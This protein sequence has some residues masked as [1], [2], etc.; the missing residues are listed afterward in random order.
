MST[1]PETQSPEPTPG[2]AETAKNTDEVQQPT[3]AAET[4]AD[5]QPESTA[6]DEGGHSE[7][8][9]PRDESRTEDAGDQSEAA[10]EADQADKGGAADQGD[11]ADQG[12]AA[13]KA[14]QADEKGSRRDEA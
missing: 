2:P 4:E 9:E 5:P 8:A 13:D 11:A 10:D 14:D 6:P 3:D 1:T 7:A 12:N